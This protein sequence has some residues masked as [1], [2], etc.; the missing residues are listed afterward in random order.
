MKD[1]NTVI[2]EEETTITIE[3]GEITMAVMTEDGEIIT[4]VMTEAEEA[5][6]METMAA[7]AE[8]VIIGAIGPN[9]VIKY[10]NGWR[11]EQREIASRKKAVCA[12]SA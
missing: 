3:D 6:I 5:A 4:V 7:T 11:I 9:G 12:N 10:L 1:H 8:T 2:G